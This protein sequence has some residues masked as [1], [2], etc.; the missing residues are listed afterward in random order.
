MTKFHYIRDVPGGV[1]FRPVF[2]CVCV[3]RSLLKSLFNFLFLFRQNFVNMSQMLKRGQ[4][5]IDMKIIAHEFPSRFRQ[6][7]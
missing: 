5:F 2:V 7:R 4:M 1:F 3:C 6:I